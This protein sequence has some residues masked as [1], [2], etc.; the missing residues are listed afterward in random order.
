VLLGI[1]LAILQEESSW[2]GLVE[3]LLVANMIIWVEVSALKLLR[4]SLGR[5]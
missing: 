4:L 2:F 3:R 1:A 5:G